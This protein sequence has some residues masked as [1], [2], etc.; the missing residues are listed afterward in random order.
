MK[1]AAAAPPTLLIRLVFFTCL[2]G[3]LCWP[4]ILEASGLAFCFAFFFCCLL[5]LPPAAADELVVSL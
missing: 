5:S 1:E 4:P 2:L 3:K